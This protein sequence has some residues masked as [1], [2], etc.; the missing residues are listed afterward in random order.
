MTTVIGIMQKI[1]LGI[2]VGGSKIRGILLDSSKKKWSFAFNAIMSKNRGKF[3]KILER[4]IAKIIK[5]K[6]IAGIG[7]GLPGI[8]DIK[9][10]ILI[11]APHLPFLKNWQAKKF[12]LT[13]NKNLKFD[14]D[15]RCFVIGEAMR[16]AG[17]RHKNIIGITIGTGI[18]GGI[19]I[20]NKIYYG[21]NYGAGEFGKMVIGNKK[22]FEQLGA[23]KAFLKTGDTSKIIGIGVANLINILDPEIVILGGGGI[24]SGKVKLGTIR[25][26]A[27]KYIMSPLGKKIPIIKGKLGENSQAIGAA[28]LFKI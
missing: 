27:K 8:V 3:L 5:K 20:N 12:L 13:F 9:N 10:G 18:G 25:K 28:L 21:E 4:E 15:S 11:K 1:Y 26:T 16:G 23:K 22:T 7:I 14:N 6:R 24:Y 19:V 2:D 17:K